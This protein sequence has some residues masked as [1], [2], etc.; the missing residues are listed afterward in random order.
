ML[1]RSCALA[2]VLAACGGTSAAPD[3]RGDDMCDDPPAGCVD[4]CDHCSDEPQWTCTCIGGAWTMQPCAPFKLSCN[5]VSQSGC[6]PGEKCA[7][8][9]DDAESG[10]GH[11][12]CVAA[13]DTVLGEPCEAP[14]GPGHGDDCVPGAHCAEGRCVEICVVDAGGCDGANVCVGFEGLD[15]DVC[16]PACDPLDPDACPGDRL[17]GCYL[18]SWGGVCAVVVGGEGQPLGGACEHLNDCAPGAGCFDD[19]VGGGLCRAYCGPLPDC[20]S[21]DGT[22]TACACGGCTADELCGG[23]AG[24]DRVGVCVPATD[25]GCD[26][27]ASPVCPTP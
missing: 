19:G 4:A 18:T 20:F 23:I 24:E 12:G 16:I 25:F 27:A 2:L 13:G 14:A 10:I 21:P 15:F 11:T 17:R 26:C 1:P 5:A 22:P 3:A 6:C 8:I 9:L 7:F